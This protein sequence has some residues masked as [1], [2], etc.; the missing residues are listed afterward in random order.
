MTTNT[1][2]Y[3]L[4]KIRQPLLLCRQAKTLACT[5]TAYCLPHTLKPAGRL[6]PGIEPCA[7]TRL[8]QP[9]CQ[10]SGSKTSG[11]VA[12]EGSASSDRNTAA[13]P[14]PPQALEVPAPAQVEPVHLTD[15]GSQESSPDAIGATPEERAEEEPAAAATVAPVPEPVAP[16][17]KSSK[18]P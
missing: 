16:T 8:I 12:G 2:R 6:S 9:A 17:L 3:S 11:P 4:L 10:F 5:S 15:T 1:Q 7:N 13:F 18:R 14:A